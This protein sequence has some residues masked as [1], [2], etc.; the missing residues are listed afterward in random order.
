MP[1]GKEK[2]TNQT[3]K[4][5]DVP[6]PGNRRFQPPPSIHEKSVSHLQF[7]VVRVSYGSVHPNT[8]LAPTF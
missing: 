1:E 4:N 7:S 5:N 2:N 6:N 3:T 8:N